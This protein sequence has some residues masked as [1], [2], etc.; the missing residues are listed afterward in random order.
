MTLKPKKKTNVKWVFDIEISC[1]LITIIGFL[2]KLEMKHKQPRV[3]NSIF[4]DDNINIIYI[5]QSISSFFVYVYKYLC[6]V[7]VDSLMRQW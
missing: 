4:Y 3:A 2:C 6:M 7:V 1:V 5:Y